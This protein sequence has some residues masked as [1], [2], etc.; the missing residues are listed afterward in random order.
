VAPAESNTKKTPGPFDG[1]AKAKEDEPIFTLLGR[2]PL[3]PPLVALWAM[4]NRIRCGL[5]QPDH[6]IWTSLVRAATASPRE[7]SDREMK[8]E[9]LQ[10]SEAEEIGWAMDEFRKGY[11]PLA[12]APQESYSGYKPDAAAQAARDENRERLE[13]SRRLD[14]S[15]AEINGVAEV[16]ERYGLTS[17]ASG[18]RGF[19]AIL[20]NISA[21]VRPQRQLP[22]TPEPAQT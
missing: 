1:F 10:T 15:V 18:L 6:A 2:D 11:E 7:L 5:G 3:A 19:A 8:A 12:H 13:A 4:M 21:E 20:K 16:A 17:R 14:N 22:P 9:L